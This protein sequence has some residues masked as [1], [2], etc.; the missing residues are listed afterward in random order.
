MHNPCET[1][2]V[3]ACCLIRQKTVWYDCGCDPY[4]LYRIWKTFNKNHHPRIAKLMFKSFERV[5]KI[6]KE[7]INISGHCSSVA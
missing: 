5:K 1:C 7:Q 4:E 2:L 6:N 3:K